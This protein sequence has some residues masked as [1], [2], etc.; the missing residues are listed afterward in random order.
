LWV[1]HNVHQRTL[2][3]RKWLWGFCNFSYINIRLVLNVTCAVCST[4]FVLINNRCH[5]PSEK[6]NFFQNVY[7]IRDFICEIWV[8]WY[9]FDSDGQPLN[10]DFRNAWSLRPKPPEHLLRAAHLSKRTH[11]ILLSVNCEWSHYVLLWVTVRTDVAIG[12]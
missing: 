9:V 5:R 1:W 7:Y 4:I 3:G 6:L 2:E 12:I 11:L 8:Q 10:A